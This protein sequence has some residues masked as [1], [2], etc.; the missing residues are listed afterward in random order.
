[1]IGDLPE[2][3]TIL[4]FLRVYNNRPTLISKDDGA[5]SVDVE[6]IPCVEVT[7]EAQLINENTREKFYIKSQPTE[8]KLD[9]MNDFKTNFEKFAKPSVARGSGK[10]RVE[11]HHVHC[12]PYD[13]VARVKNDPKY[14]EGKNKTVFYPRVYIKKMNL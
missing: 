10:I 14:N 2:E 7:Y 12:V 1:M 13:V 6:E 8:F 4:E 3:F 11:M 5:R 9:I